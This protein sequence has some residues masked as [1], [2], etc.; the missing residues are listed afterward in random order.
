[1]GEIFTQD[2]VLRALRMECRAAGS[3]Q[4]WADLHG[5]PTRYVCE[6]LNGRRPI[7][8]SIA[9]ALGFRK[10]DRWEEV[11]PDA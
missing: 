3:V 9:T 10:V 5:I 6:A 1:M 8:L 7:G 4:A 11:H 2:D